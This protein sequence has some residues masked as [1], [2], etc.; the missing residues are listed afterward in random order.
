LSGEG[1]AGDNNW[2][3]ATGALPPSTSNVDVN[4][5]KNVSVIYYPRNS[6]NSSIQQWNAQFEREFGGN[7]ALHVGYVGTKMS[8][9]ATAFN[10]NATPLGG[11]PSAW[12]GLGGNVNEYAY[13]GSGTY[14]GLQ[15]SLN[16]RM[17]KGLQFTTAYTWSHTID[18][19]NGAFSTTV[20]QSGG[21]IFVDSHGNPQLDLNKGNADQD[22]RHFFVFSSLY[23]IPF[24]KGRQFG[25]DIPT[26][27]NYII[28]G[29]QWNNIVTLSTGTP[30]DLTI[31][32]ASPANRPDVTGPVKVTIGTTGC[33]KGVAECGNIIGNFSTPPNTRPG[34]LGR[35]SLYG[36]GYHTW[37]TGM[38]KEFSVRERLKLEF[39]ADVFNLF[40]TPQ[41]QNASFNATVNGGSN[42]TTNPAATRF[43]SERQL[44]LAVRITF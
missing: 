36:P 24:G 42:G 31:N 28:G 22:I 10:A 5:P 41:F 1:P 38:N 40:N 7:T 2:L 20:G 27:L 35:N 4:D 23:E 6:K 9:L 21:K 13:I 34:T 26:A 19:S 43:S 25:T 14:N 29:W 39:R 12:S 8:N 33:A 3:D 16:R 17:T 18:N 32:G 44:Q 37:D 11:G 15:T 30:L